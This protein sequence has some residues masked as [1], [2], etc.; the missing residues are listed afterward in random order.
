[1]AMRA[2]QCGARMNAGPRRK[3]K[4]LITQPGKI[5]RVAKCV[6]SNACAPEAA[7]CAIAKARPVVKIAKAAAAAGSAQLA[8]EIERCEKRKAKNGVIGGEA[9]PRGVVF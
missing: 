2:L 5:R 6:A 3:K 8:D 7:S 4:Q 1:M 9:A